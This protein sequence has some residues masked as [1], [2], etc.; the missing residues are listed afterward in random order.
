MWILCIGTYCF[1]LVGIAE[2]VCSPLILEHNTMM[3]FECSMFVLNCACS[4]EGT[5]KLQDGFTNKFEDKP[6]Y[7]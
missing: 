1:I 3:S 4:Q 6:W 2:N 5:S 7:W